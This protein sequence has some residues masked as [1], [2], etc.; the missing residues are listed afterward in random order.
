MRFPGSLVDRPER[1]LIF[2]EGDLGVDDERLPTGDTDDHVRAKPPFLGGDADFGRKVAML[3]QSAS[4][5]HVA[6]LLLTPAPARL[7]CVPKG[8]DQLRSFRRDALGP[9]THRI[10]L[11][12]K[13]AK[14]VPPLGFH[15]CDSLLVAL[16][17]LV[18]G[19]QQCLEIAARIL[20]G[21]PKPLVGAFQ[22]RLLR[23]GEQF[24][25]DL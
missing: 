3:R 8:I 9:G 5:E 22:K 19:L 21:L 16:Q 7:G 20:L 15:L 25:A 11:A 24:V 12:R 1:I 13:H 23:L 17:P 18:N 4:L 14:R 2:I 6:K 10:D